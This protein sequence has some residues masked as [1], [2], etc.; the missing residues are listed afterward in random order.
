MPWTETAPRPQKLAAMITK[1]SPSTLANCLRKSTPFLAVPLLQPQLGDEAA[2]GRPVHL[3]ICLT[4]LMSLYRRE[5]NRG[6]G[7]LAVLVTISVIRSAKF[8]DSAK[9]F[10]RKR[11]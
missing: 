7:A 10:R 1:Q 6:L 4:M 3:I 9:F 5:D 11:S 2:N 8:S